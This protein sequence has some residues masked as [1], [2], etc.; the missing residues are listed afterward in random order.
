MD[1]GWD[2]IALFAGALAA[3]G[4][5]TVPAPAAESPRGGAAILLRSGAWDPLAAVEQS[6]AVKAGAASGAAAESA[7]GSGARALAAGESEVLLL[8]WTSPPTVAS[9]AALRARGIRL[10]Q[11]IPP[12]AHL[13]LCEPSAA[14]AAASAAATGAGAPLELP[15]RWAGALPARAKCDPALDSLY[16][17]CLAAPSAA[18]TSD[19]STTR[20]LA[21][22]LILALSGGEKTLEAFLAGRGGRVIRRTQWPESA[23]ARWVIEAPAAAVAEIAA[24]NCVL[25]IAPWRAPSRC[26]ERDALIAAGLTTPNGLC[27][28][29][30]GGGYQDWLDAAG[31]TGGE[32]YIVMVSDDGISQGIATGAPGTAHPDI[33]GRI[34]GIDNAT[35]DPKG[36]SGDGHGHINAAIIISQPK[37]TGQVV[38]DSAGFLFGQGVAPRAR[39]W[40][41]KIFNNAGEFDQGSR[42]D[43]DLV[44]AAR[45]AGA[46]F[47]NNSWGIENSYGAYDSLAVEYD[48][49]VRDAD[50]GTAG[51]QPITAIFAA[52]N[53]GEKGAGTINS[54]STAKNVISVGASEGCDA[55]PTDGCLVTSAESDSIRDVTSFSGRGPTAD[56]RIG[57]TLSAPG[58]HVISGASDSPSYDGSGVCGLSNS[59]YYPLGQTRYTWSSGT[60]HAAPV[61]SGAAVIFS[62]YYKKRNG[63]DP[64]PA[65]LKA[66]LITTAVDLAG[67]SS[68]DGNTIAP[69]P[70][71][72]QGWGRVALDPLVNPARPFYFEDQDYR[73]VQDGE[74]VERLLQVAAPGAPLRV[75]LAWTDAPGFAGAQRA[76][77]NDLDLEVRRGSDVWRGNAFSQGATVANGGSPDRVNNVECVLIPNAPAGVYTV[78]ITAYAIRGDALPL[79]G[80]ALEQDFALAAWNAAPQLSQGV[81]Q[82]DRARHGC[83]D[84]IEV[85]LSDA[86]LRGQDTVPILASCPATGDSEA[87][88]LEEFPAGEGIFYATLPTTTNP[89]VA[90]DGFLSVVEGAAA[91]FRYE[92]EDD[93]YGEPRITEEQTLID[94]TPPVLLTHRLDSRTENSASF[95]LSA[96]EP[97]FFYLD[98]GYA[99]DSLTETSANMILATTTTLELAGLAPCSVV[100]YTLTLMDEAGNTALY[101]NAGAPF[102]F[103]TRYISAIFRDTM[104]PAAAAGWTSRADRGVNDWQVRAASA[105][106]FSPPN[107]WFTSDSDGIKDASLITPP[108]EIPAGA[109]MTFYHTYSFEETFDGGVIEISVDGGATWTDL[110]DSIV[111]NGYDAALSRNFQNPIG[112]RY[113][114]TGGSLGAMRRVQVNL[115]EYAGAARKIRWRVAC[116]VD[117]GDDGWYIDNIELQAY[118]ECVSAAARLTIEPGAMDCA[119]VFTLRVS[120][121]SLAGAEGATVWAAISSAPQAPVELFLNTPVSPGVFEGTLEVAP[122]TGRDRLIVGGALSAAPGE[123]LI[124]TYMDRV[125]PACPEIPRVAAARLDCSFTPPPGGWIFY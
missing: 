25:W 114:W 88:T 7:S 20:P 3:L 80:A 102:Y 64:S 125:A 87:L 31:L 43:T 42:T 71:G 67:G 86:D 116:D 27:V 85:S 74:A 68:N 50:P 10:I 91:V 119:G 24:F 57:P 44:Q 103:E 79:D 6:G 63:A 17:A 53:D 69:I 113:A 49:L 112:G 40:A 96:D 61:V 81:I 38:S 45:R 100:C 13:A 109:L 46:L 110:G 99:C 32:G 5:F 12:N 59:W 1:R 21:L 65:L 94:C 56:Q 14:R 108:L 37:V 97:A 48:R 33:L 104:D 66:A 78:R 120:D 101:Q 89:A 39:V 118:T 70:N 34:A 52:G 51:Y 72:V 4:A 107:T 26:G 19:A 82:F 55:G 77:V 36:D 124:I 84:A 9:E 11:F 75:T 58:T 62:E 54:P 60:S 115:G 111:E 16:D 15:L 23:Q 22:D 83:D 18:S 47:T 41:T 29:G 123:D 106:A 122:S 2:W 73:F 90:N 121:A 35:A 95:T 105:Y 117:T 28:Q 98:Y 92:D 93:G 30:A 8:Q 76:L